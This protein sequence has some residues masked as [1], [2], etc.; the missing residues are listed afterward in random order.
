MNTSLIE[1]PGRRTRRRHSPEFKAGIIEACR[2]P[3]VSIAAVS[4]ANGLNPNMVRKWVIDAEALPD[5]E[6][7]RQ[8]GFG[9]ASEQPAAVAA[10]TPG[11]V[12]LA[13]KPASA[14]A[15]IRIE[16]TR[17]TTAIKVCWP[18][19]AAAECAVWLREMLR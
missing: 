19:S 18:T 17:G 14:T 3:G 4:L 7:E 16:L 8:V 5:S 15:E 6:V 13:L 12:A 10:S 1:L 11:F 2:K 9:P